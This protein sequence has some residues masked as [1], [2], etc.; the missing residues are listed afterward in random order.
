MQSCHGCLPTV[1][2]RTGIDSSSACLQQPLRIISSSFQQA[3]GPSRE[4]AMSALTA[5]CANATCPAASLRLQPAGC[6]SVRSPIP[7]VARQRRTWARRAIGSQRHAAAAR[8]ACRQGV[9]CAQQRQQRQQQGGVSVDQVSSKGL[10]ARQHQKAAPLCSPMVNT[11]GAILMA[12]RQ[13]HKAYR[14]WIAERR[15]GRGGYISAVQRDSPPSVTA[16]ICR[17]LHLQAQGPSGGGVQP[18]SQRMVAAVAVA[19]IALGPLSGPLLA[20]PPAAAVLNSPN[21]QIARSADV[22]LRHSIP[23]EPPL[24]RI[25]Q[26]CTAATAWCQLCQLKCQ[27]KWA[28]KYRT[29]FSEA[30]CP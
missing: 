6:Q 25:T 22:A 13:L 29:S 17:I 2:V 12:C 7:F 15:A 16:S 19:A 20:P 11:D 10:L 21:A 8:A 5:S 24:Q 27:L 26:W 1:L 14:F 28:V 9:Q 30:A 18:L 4:P 23:G 3:A